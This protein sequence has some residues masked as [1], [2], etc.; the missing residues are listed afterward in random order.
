MSDEV[1]FIPCYILVD[2]DADED[3]WTD[4]DIAWNEEFW[5]MLD[6]E[7]SIVDAQDT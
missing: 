7:R 2:P 4:A 1:V 3:G 6:E 5:A